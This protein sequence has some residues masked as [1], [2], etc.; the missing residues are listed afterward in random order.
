[1]KKN[2][3]DTTAQKGRKPFFARLLEAQELEHVAGGVRPSSLTRKAPS[4]HEE[5]STT[6]KYPSDSDEVA[7]TLKYPSDNEDS[8]R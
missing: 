1:M 3:K 8:C 5:V 2:E 6:E 7:T 4:D